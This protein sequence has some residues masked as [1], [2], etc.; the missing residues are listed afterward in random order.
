MKTCL[1]ATCGIEID[2]VGRVRP[3]CLA[4]PFTD[5]N[6]NEYNLSKDSL[7]D[8]WHSESRKQF[9]RD[10]EDGI[11]NPTCEICWVEEKN[12]RESKRQRENNRD[13][14]PSD[15]PQLLDLK[16]GNTCN[17]RCRT[18]NPD[19]SSSWVNEWYDVNEQWQNKAE[20]L[21]KYKK[22]QH[23]YDDSNTNVW[24]AL[25][26]WIPKAHTIDFYGG[27]PLLI[28]RTWEILRESVENGNAKSQ[29]LHYNTNAT[30]F[31]SEDQIAILLKFKKVNISLSIDGIDSA[32][33]FMRY[34][35]K[36]DNVLNVI[37]KYSTLMEN[38]N[39]IKVDFCYTVSL[40]NIWD[41]VEF[42]R[43]VT[44]NFPH[45]GIYY[46]MLFTPTYLSITNIPE[47]IKEIVRDRLLNYSNKMDVITSM[48]GS[49]ES[50]SK[51][52][53]EFLRVTSTHDKYRNNTFK[54]SFPV[55]HSIL[56]E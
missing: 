51:E 43:F 20:F 24:D 54:E 48:L 35:A 17:L 49:K 9:L 45:V 55:W 31:P 11:E 18:C 28:K 12:G 22:I 5:Q 44:E 37:R 41:T 4:K 47:N 33:E 27:E 52:Y 34:P 21:S 38:S 7:Q 3:C 26:D 2:T 6:G 1:Q 25:V 39:N 23:I 15:T 14:I 13:L 10:L 46:N 50:D 8:I 53:G 19:S 42:D 56:V 32:F 29:E 16:L 30:I 40:Y 36:W